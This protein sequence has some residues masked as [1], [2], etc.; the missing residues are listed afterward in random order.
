MEKIFSLIDA[1]DKIGLKS[2]VSNEGVAIHT[3]RDGRG[4]TVLHHAA[5][6][7][8]DEMAKECMDMVRN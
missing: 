8:N 1:R 6:H 4:Y 7:A 5:F 2:F 3:L